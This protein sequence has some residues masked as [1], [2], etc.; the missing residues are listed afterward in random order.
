[1]RSVR[2]APQ[3]ALGWLWPDKQSSPRLQI[4]P[5]CRNFKEPQSCY[6]REGKTNIY[7]AF[8]QLNPGRICSLWFLSDFQSF[9]SLTQ[10]LLAFIVLLR[11]KYFKSFSEEM[12]HSSCVGPVEDRHRFVGMLAQA[13]FFSSSPIFSIRL[14]SGLC[15]NHSSTSTLVCLNHFTT[16]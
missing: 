3:T 8:P 14:R 5:E 12:A 15:Y 9:R 10:Y 11:V 6:W 4:P 1:M 2:G 16:A 7:R 13:H